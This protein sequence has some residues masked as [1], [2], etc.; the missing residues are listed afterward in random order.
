ML[1]AVVARTTSLYARDILV[2]EDETDNRAWVTFRNRIMMGSS[3][4][5][6]RSVAATSIENTLK[7]VLMSAE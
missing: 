6:S 4:R 2:T 3:L 1:H 7:T 5:S